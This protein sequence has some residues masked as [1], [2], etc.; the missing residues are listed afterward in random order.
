MVLA[1]LVIGVLDFSTGAQVRL[2]PFYAGPIFVVAWFWN[3]RTALLFALASG[4]VSLTADWLTNDPDLRGWFKIWEITRHLSS[5]V[6]VSLIASILRQKHDSAA[7]RIAL[8]EHSQRLEREIV[9]IRDAEQSRIG[10]DLHDG[11][12]QYLAALTCSATSLSDDL[13]KLR[14]K[15]EAEAA[16]ELAELL[17][18]A[19]VQ[20]RDLARGLVPAHVRQ[21]GLPLALESLAQSVSRLNG[22]KCTFE[23]RGESRTF[24]DRV[25]RNLYRIAQEAINNAIRHGKA[26]QIGIL[27]ES[28]RSVVKL[29]VRDDGTGLNTSTANFSG[30]GLD[31]MRYRANQ[32]GGELRIHRSPTGGTIVSCN[33][34][35][36]DEATEVAAA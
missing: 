1:L 7:A 29:Q 6:V 14:L 18:Q 23:F 27:L 20:T 24:E 2:L 3:K 34:P 26:G 33:A 15:N 5:C 22:I 28:G 12:C 30:M 11:L 36:S 10:Q 4:I 16:G 17:Q 19:V 25:A 9:G 8:L 21:M 35:I 13:Q 32:N 31:I